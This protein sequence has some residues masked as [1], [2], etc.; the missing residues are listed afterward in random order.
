MKCKLGAKAHCTHHL[1]NR[2]RQLRSHWTKQPRPKYCVVFTCSLSCC[3][4]FSSSFS[5]CGN[6]LHSDILLQVGAMQAGNVYRPT[7]DT[8]GRHRKLLADLADTVLQHAKVIMHGSPSG[9]LLLH[10]GC[11]VLCCAVLCCAVLCCAVLCCEITCS[12]VLLFGTR[13]CPVWCY[14]VLAEIMTSLLQPWQHAW[15]LYVCEIIIGLNT[16]LL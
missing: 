11:A 14:T 13:C 9:C 2:Q 8:H 16:G 5:A 7:E 12:Y 6:D 10:E 3:A 15:N 1:K 4:H